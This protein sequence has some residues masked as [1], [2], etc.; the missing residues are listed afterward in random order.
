MDWTEIAVVF[1]AKLLFYLSI[2]CVAMFL[3]DE[4]I[5]KRYKKKK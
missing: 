4:L 2:F 5:V 3:I 1:L